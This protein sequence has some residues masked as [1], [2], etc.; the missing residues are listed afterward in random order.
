MN[1]NKLIRVFTTLALLFILS[2]GNIGGCTKSENGDDNN[3]EPT[4][5]ASPPPATPEPTPTASPS[6]P[7]PS[8]TPTAPP[9]VPPVTPEPP[10]IPPMQE[11]GQKNSA[12]A[13]ANVCANLIES[14][15]ANE[16][17]EQLLAV[18]RDSVEQIMKLDL[19]DGSSDLPVAI[20]TIRS[21]LI[22]I[23]ARASEEVSEIAE[24][25]ASICEE[26]IN[27]L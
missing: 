22:T 6:P 16:T 10:D 5:S 1:K 17:D 24:N 11:T 8:P 15:S 26:D 19:P 3:P 2:I 9:Q 25:L 20:G 27:E 23:T 18:Y 13:I 14:T 7:T 4:P 21:A 12:T